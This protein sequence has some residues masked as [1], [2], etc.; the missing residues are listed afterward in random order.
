M[1]RKYHIMGSIASSV[2]QYESYRY[3]VYCNTPT[4]L[5]LHLSDQQFYCLRHVRCG[6]NYRFYSIICFEYT[7]MAVDGLV[8]R[9]ARA[10]V[11]MIASLLTVPDLC[12]ASFFWGTVA[13][14]DSLFYLLL[15][16]FSLNF[17]IFFSYTVHSRYHFFSSKN[18]LWVRFELSCV[19]LL[20][21]QSYSFPPFVFHIVQYHVVSDCNILR[22]EILQFCTN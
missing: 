19:S 18:A 2:S 4:M 12:M 21:E 5:Q 15:F 14:K 3:R 17:N 20:S 16:N 8:T 7:I 11:A 22:M 9:G 13:H 10:S 6:L 1:Y